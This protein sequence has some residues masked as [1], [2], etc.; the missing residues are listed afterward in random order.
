M[1][2]YIKR[3]YDVTKVSKKNRG[4]TASPSNTCG[5]EYKAIFDMMAFTCQNI[6]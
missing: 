3:N 1:L 2:T 4:A 6:V 5:C